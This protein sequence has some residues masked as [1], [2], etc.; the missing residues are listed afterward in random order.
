MDTH[1][2]KATDSPQHVS[3]D[4]QSN[5]EHSSLK[6]HHDMSRVNAHNLPL[7]KKL[8]AT[9]ASWFAVLY[10]FPSSINIETDINS[11][12]VYAATVATPLIPAIPAQLNTTP[13]LAHLVFTAPFMGVFFAPIYTPHASEIAGRKPVY[14]VSIS[15]F[16]IVVGGISAAKT[17][18]QI[19]V[20]RFIAGLVGGPLA[21]LIEGTH[22]DVWPA[23]K[24][25]SYYCSIALSQY[26]GASL[27][28]VIG[29]AALTYGG[30]PF[31][32]YSAL[33]FGAFAWVLIATMPETFERQ[34][35]RQAI[36]RGADI[37]L[38][39]APTGTKI[40]TMLNLTVWTPIKMLFTEPLVLMGTL[41]LGLSFA[42]VFQWFI[43]VP[44]ALINIY[45]L[46]AF[47]ISI[48]FFSPF[49]GAA[50]AFITS[51]VIDSFASRTMTESGPKIEQRLFSA[52][53]G[54]L[55]TTGSLFWVAWTAKP[56]VHYIVPV[57]GNAVY[58][59][60]NMMIL[61]S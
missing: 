45:Q 27:G 6:M 60:G 22:A 32:A 58:V 1:V 55:L 50:M 8:H 53:V 9:I 29:Q 10:G 26:W 40:T 38:K 36:K 16:L 23:K 25:V 18:S 15:L 3:N 49:T 42:V 20:L 4:S 39:P 19:I 11:T 46:D 34:L 33:F 48:V 7:L 52:M 30:V 31:T 12:L 21:V 41:L 35:V 54:V 56:S 13:T 59:W 5:P 51:L 61:V 57:T 43:T 47:N 17:V 28:P 14:L 44:F 37:Q 24:T 2:E